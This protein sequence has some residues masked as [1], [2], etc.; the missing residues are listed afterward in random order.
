MAQEAE[1]PRL[2]TRDSAVTLIAL[3]LLVVLSW[4]YL[5]R[6]PRHSREMAAPAAAMA[7][8]APPRPMTE[9]AQ[10]TTDD[11]EDDDVPRFP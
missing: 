1:A 2:L 7:S 11:A 9:D 4:A 10:P 5:L 3:A 8:V 6:A